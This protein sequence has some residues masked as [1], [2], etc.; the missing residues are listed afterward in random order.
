MQATLASPRSGDPELAR[1]SQREQTN[2]GYRRETRR[3]ASFGLLLW[4]FQQTVQSSTCFID[5]GEHVEKA[6]I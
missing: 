6:L 1:R 5:L 3:L 2:S 4:P